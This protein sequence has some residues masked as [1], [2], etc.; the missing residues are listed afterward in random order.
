MASLVDICNSALNQLGA[1][2]II[3]LT[4][5]SKNARII[6]QR[7]DSVRDQVFREHPWNALTKRIKLAQDSQAP[8]YEFSFAYTLPS[9][10]LKVLSFSD[11]TSEYLAKND[12]NY[13]I[14]NGKLLTSSSVVYLKYIA[15]E[16]DTSK[17]DSSLSETISAALAADIA[18]AITGSTTVMQLFEGKYKEKLKDAR[19]ADAT[20]GMPEELDADFPFIASRY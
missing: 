6:S 17:Y 1:S 3:S 15:R 11:S 8:V 19:F 12:I 9:D 2:T 13:K 5:N 7:F 14:E 4:E 10:C 16:T 18:Y 20:E